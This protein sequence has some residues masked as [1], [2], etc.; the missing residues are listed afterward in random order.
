LATNA[1]EIT[2]ELSCAKFPPADQ[3]EQLWKDNKDALINFIW[4]SQLGIKGVVTDANTGA[5]I[6]DAIVWIVNVTEAANSDQPINHPVTTAEGGDYW[7]LLTKGKFEVI[8]KAD[9]YEVATKTVEVT[10]PEQMEAQRVDF[11]LVPSTESLNAGET[12]DSDESAVPSEADLQQV[13]EG[14]PQN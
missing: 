2:L 4:Q 5:P 11:K 3:L 6:E 8:V 7:R 14:L 10:N 9:G 1:F 12:S 13:L